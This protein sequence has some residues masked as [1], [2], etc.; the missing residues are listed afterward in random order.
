MFIH[1]FSVYV[2]STSYFLFLLF[3]IYLGFQLGTGQISL[4]PGLPPAP[5]L[6]WMPSRNS[7]PQNLHR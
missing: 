5:T 6:T 7:A 4:V 3:S 2:L 1:Y